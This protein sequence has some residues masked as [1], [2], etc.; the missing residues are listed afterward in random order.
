MSIV[1]AYVTAP[2]R[3]GAERIGRTLV[4]ERLAACVNVLDGMTSIY[5]WKGAVE[6]TQ[7]A[8]LIAKTRADIFTLLAARV[9]ELHPYETPCV[10]EI[11][12]G[13]GD[14]GYLA[15]LSALGGD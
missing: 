5:R 10:V 9:R 15:W 14:A 8:V 4:D 2:D 7:E 1:F 13:R 6:A 11:P 3:D 12:V